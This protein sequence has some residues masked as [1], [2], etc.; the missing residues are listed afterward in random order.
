MLSHSHKVRK[1]GFSLVELLVVI[2]ILGILISL[3]LPA[4][5][6]ARE[7][8][9]RMQCF[10]N[11][12]QISI[13]L[14]S[15]H[16]VHQAFPPGCFD[17]T[18]KVIAWSVFI[19]PHIEQD[20]LHQ[21]FH[22]DKAHNAPENASATHA[23][24]STYLCPST[25]L[26]SSGRIGNFSVRYKLN[27]TPYADSGMGAID[28]GGM[29]G[30]SVGNTQKLGVMIYDRSVS[31][32]EIL[33]GTSNTIAVAEDTGRGYEDNGEWADGQNIFD[34]TGGINVTQNNEMWSDHPNGV[35]AAF[36]DGSAHFL[37]QTLDLAVVEALCTRSSGEIIS[38]NAFP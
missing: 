2:T 13:G 31:I 7:A 36:C 19:L 34:Q 32:A 37:P 30:W 4:V 11:L 6:S 17:H 24:I 20:G 18:K 38:G 33:D 1:S 12:H 27:G 22:Y 25:N 23:A 3:L 10:N 5:Q 35:N 8:A 9:R 28:Y 15:Y 16:A 21:L 14:H 29:Y 26:M